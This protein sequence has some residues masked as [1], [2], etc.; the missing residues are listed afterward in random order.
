MSHLPL[1]QCTPKVYARLGQAL[2]SW[3]PCNECLN[4]DDIKAAPCCECPVDRADRYFRFYQAVVHEYYASSISPIFKNHHDLFRAIIRLRTNPQTT[5]NEL[6]EFIAP[7]CSDVDEQT[8]A[9]ALV[10]RIV[11]MVECST[12]YQ[13]AD[14]LEKGLSNV[15]WNE[16]TS[17]NSYIGG[18]FSNQNSATLQCLLW[19]S[20][21]R[22]GSKSTLRA[23]KLRKRLKLRLRP[24][25]DL[26]NHLK[27]NRQ[28]GELEI[29]HHAA[30][31][32]EQLWATNA[33]RRQGGTSNATASATLLPRQL[34][35]EILDSLQRILF[36]LDDAASKRLLRRLIKSSDTAF[37]PSLLQFEYSSLIHATEN[38][39]KEDQEGHSNS[40]N[41][42]AGGGAVRYQ[43]LGSR[44]AELRE[45]LENPPPR[46]WFDRQFAAPEQRPLRHDGDAGG[47]GVCSLVAHDE[48][49]SDV[50]RVSGM[51]E[52][53]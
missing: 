9:T 46:R 44:L 41:S 17:I 38:D 15:P 12:I 29:F 42:M 48:R 24:T 23:T 16:N 8:S 2:W 34:L 40:R 11:V 30:F 31:L 26:R 19:D 47:S 43:Y 27:L 1:D 20:D 28:G 6:L 14:R 36:P 53:L 52:A 51:E 39:G 33:H 13:S 18:F 4:T 35:L 3:E 25:H 7:S 50:D 21:L 10:T 49:H 37:D 5:R 32:K 22:H 45:E